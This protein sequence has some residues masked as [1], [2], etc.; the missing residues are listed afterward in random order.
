M[1]RHLAVSVLAVSVLALFATSSCSLAADAQ[2]EQDDPRDQ[3]RLGDLVEQF[4]Q[5]LPTEQAALQQEAI[6]SGHLY[7]L[8]V[9][10]KEVWVILR[11]PQDRRE[12]FV[13]QLPAEWKPILEGTEE[14]NAG[15]ILASVRQGFDQLVA[16]IRAKNA[17]GEQVGKD[18]EH[19]QALGGQVTEQY[20]DELLARLSGSGASPEV[21]A[22]GAR[23]KAAADARLASQPSPY[24]AA[25]GDEA[26]TKDVRALYVYLESIKMVAFK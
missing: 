4:M 12:P 8:D 6:E 11:D 3:E 26:E 24:L 19:F 13:I 20:L 7:V 21:K 22:A 25:G 14:A 18:T 9:A 17:F 5:E 1:K 16:K 23:L 10:G 15:D 2:Q